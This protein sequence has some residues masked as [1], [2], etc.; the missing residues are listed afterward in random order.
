LLHLV[1]LNLQ[2]GEKFQ[3]P[4]IGANNLSGIVQSDTALDLTA[5][6]EIGWATWSLY[7]RNGGFGTFL[8]IF[9]RAL[10]KS[11]ES[12]VTATV[13]LDTVDADTNWSVAYWATVVQAVAI[14][15]TDGTAIRT[16]T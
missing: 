9:Y 8:Q 13:P 12:S 11:R 6:A 14:D 7:F 15:P 16:S 5:T 2:S 4:L 3:Q 10:E 1:A